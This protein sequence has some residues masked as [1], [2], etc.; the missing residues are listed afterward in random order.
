MWGYCVVEVQECS[1]RKAVRHWRT[2]AGQ[3]WG[4]DTQGTGR[5]RLENA[6]ELED[7]TSDS[8]HLPEGTQHS[9][10]SADSSIGAEETLAKEE[11]GWLLVDMR[12]AAG[13]MGWQAGGQRVLCWSI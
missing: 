2:E 12:L 10:G 11:A 6:E 7:L 1:E 13:V 5:L 4:P 3:Y 9:A 8:D